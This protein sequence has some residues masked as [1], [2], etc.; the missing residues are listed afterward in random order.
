MR[1]MDS[2]LSS[3]Q[4]GNDW[5][6]S[7]MKAFMGC[8]F[9]SISLFPIC[10]SSCCACSVQG[11]AISMNKYIQEFRL[12]K[13]LPAIYH[14]ISYLLDLFYYCFRICII[15]GRA[16]VFGRDWLYNFF[17]LLFI[18]YCNYPWQFLFAPFFVQTW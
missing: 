18:P 7:W 4:V 3:A 17:Q 5:T 16:R 6:M 12:C 1:I 2:P 15:R 8:A 11:Q 14:Y 13:S 10:R 9:C